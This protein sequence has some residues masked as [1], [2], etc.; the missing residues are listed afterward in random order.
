MTRRE[1]RDLG[2]V[3]GAA[4]A[5][6]VALWWVLPRETLVSDEPEYLGAAWWL[7]NGRGFSF[8]AAWPWLRPPVYLLFL[9]PFL[10]LWGLNLLPIRLAQIL[11]SLSVPALVYL[12][13]REMFGPRVARTAGWL[14]ALWLPLA[15]LPHLALAENLFLPLLLAGFY[16]L[17]RFRQRRG[18]A[19]AAAAGLGLGLATLTRGLTIAFLPVAALWMVVAGGGGVGARHLCDL[20]QYRARA[21]EAT[22]GK[23]PNRGAKM[24]RP[25]AAALVLTLAAALVILP[26]TGYN[27]LRYGR[28]ILVD[29]TGGYNFWLGTQGGQF[30]HVRDVHQALLDQPDPA[31]RQSYAYAQGF[32]ALSA[33]PLEYLRTRGTELEQLLR[34][35][36]SADERLVDGFVLGQV[37]V[38]HLLAVLLLEDT[39]Y[40]L[41]VPLALFGLL[42]HRRHAGWGLTLLWLGYNLAVAAAF[43]AINRFRLPVMPFLMVYAAAAVGAR[44]SPDPARGG[45]VGERHL[46]DLSQ[47]HARADEATPGKPPNRVAKM[48]RPYAAAVALLLT[49]AF[50][51][52]ALP[53]YAGPYPAALG[54]TIL[55]VRGRAAAGHLARA[56]AARQAGDREG[57]WAEL[58]R[59]QEYRP[60]GLN[61]APTTLVAVA[62]WQRA[63]GGA[64]GA[65]V[66]LEGVDWYQAALLR[67]DILRAQ[68]DL[69]GARREFGAR[70]VAERDALPWAWSH[71]QPPAGREV[72]VGGGLDLGLVDGFYAPENEGATTYRWSGAQARL[73]FPAAGTGRPLTLYLRLRGWR[74]A[75]EPP[76]AVVLSCDGVEVARFTA[77]QEWQEITAQLPAVPAGGEIVVTL[78]STAFFPG[79][80]DLL[81]TGRLRMLGVMVDRAAARE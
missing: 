12:L 75:G 77:A 13:G 32:A 6:R 71:L 4:L 29:T 69:A 64:A 20:S 54:A 80:Q 78:Q 67:G 42:L 61:P 27:Y 7:A 35:N 39:L 57:A 79:P 70:E 51:A 19:W 25:Y 22:P 73:R 50:G 46:R 11:I 72:D 45:G 10:R 40:L 36:Y 14:A 28:L 23:P 65:L 66:T 9:A 26:W 76:A 24:P 41:L 48:P 1:W 59:A 31:A 68:G 55:G 56:A 15:V 5:L 2:I 62:E 3:L 17:L 8:Y 49:L 43:F 21:D 37:A 47:Y 53:S 30:H 34:I 52:V 81:L 60:D 44:H 33:D 63:G 74:P 38:P 18:W 16:A 58:Q